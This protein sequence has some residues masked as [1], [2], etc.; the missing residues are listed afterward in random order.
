MI[1]SKRVR[2]VSLVELMVAV[3]V[4]AV[5]LAVAVPSYRGVIKRNQV[6][7]ASNALLADL[8]YAR[9]EAVTRGTIV[10]VCPSTDG[11]H[12]DSNTAYKSG[13]MIYAYEPGKGKADT[14]YDSAST[15]NSLLRY[16]TARAGVS[17]LAADAKVVSLGPQGEFKSS[18]SGTAARTSTRFA[19]C[20][21]AKETDSA[22]QSTAAIPGVLLSLGGSGSVSSTPL[23]NSASCSP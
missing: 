22:G 11:I 1:T 8:S 9:S 4:L 12:C 23:G 13:W 10:S 7:A 5:L 18:G 3:G 16:T 19:V 17:I 15:D 20:S 6:S 21:L 14:A 2:G